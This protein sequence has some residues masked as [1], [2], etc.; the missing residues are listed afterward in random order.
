[1]SRMDWGE[2][3]RDRTSYFA[4]LATDARVDGPVEDCLRATMPAHIKADLVGNG[5]PSSSSVRW[6]VRPRSKRF[7]RA[8]QPTRFPSRV[9]GAD[10][11]QSTSSA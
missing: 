7:T 9:S 6:K 10:S 11:H 2:V 4:A 3:E 1:M 8:N 5:K